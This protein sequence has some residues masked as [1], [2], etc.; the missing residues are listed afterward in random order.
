MSPH[1]Q[2]NGGVNENWEAEIA[3]YDAEQAAVEENF[4][5]HYLLFGGAENADL[6]EDENAVFGMVLQ[7]IPLSEI[8]EQAGVDE[9]T[10][11]GLVEIIRAKLSLSD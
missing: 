7:G 5:K 10:I 4:R 11:A 6:T 1:R 3:K 9:D 2:K 8:A